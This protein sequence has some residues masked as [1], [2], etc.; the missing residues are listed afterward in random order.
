MDSWMW[1]LL[2]KVWSFP[3]LDQAVG[4]NPDC[5]A[6]EC[7]SGCHQEKRHL[8][9]KRNRINLGAKAGNINSNSNSV[10]KM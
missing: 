6:T 8:L 1:S 4:L 2:V 5:K 10:Q 3:P 9:C 7:W